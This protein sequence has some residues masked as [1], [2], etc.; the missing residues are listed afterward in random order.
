[1][2]DRLI[3]LACLELQTLNPD[4]I[5]K[6]AGVVQ[7]LKNWFKYQTNSEFKKIVDE[8]KLKSLN[9]K[10]ILKNISNEIDNF[11]EAISNGDMASYELSVQNLKNLTQ[12]LW[13]DVQETS[14][15]GKDYYTLQDLEQPGFSEWFK[16]HLPSEYDLE[17][18]KSYNSPISEFKW[19][20][21]L[22]PDQ[23]S[24]SNKS[25]AILLNQ[26]QKTLELSAEDSSKYLN[27]IEEI[28]NRF[29]ISIVQGTLLKTNIKKPSKSIEQQILGSTEIEVLTSPF[30]LPNS[31]YKLQAKV[32][33]ID[34]STSIVPRKKLSIRKIHF[35]TSLGQKLAF[36]NSPIP[37]AVTQ[38]SELDFAKVLRSSY[39]KTFGKDPSAEILAYGWAQ[40]V[41]ESGRP[42]K[43]PNNNIGNLKA[44][45]N[46]INA[47]KPYFVKST[48]EF[49]P[50][51]ER[52]IEEGASWQA[53]SSPEEGGIAYWKLLKNKFPEALAWMASGDPDSATINLAKKHYFTANIEKYAKGVS[54]L[55]QQFMKKLTPQLPNL[56]SN[57]QNPPGEKPEM[58]SWLN[59]Y[60]QNPQN[61]N[62]QIDQLLTNLYANDGKVTTF[63]KNAKYNEILPSTTVLILVEGQNIEDKINWAL[64][65]GQISQDLIQGTFNIFKKD[66]KIE[67]EIAARGLPL[68][69]G[70]AVQAIADCVSDGIDNKIYGIGGIN[71]FSNLE[72]LSY[73]KII[74]FQR[75]FLLKQAMRNL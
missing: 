30:S 46:W 16:K 34:L 43:L 63:I 49:S 72:K 54:S 28:K 11:N 32:D 51:G 69:V 73:S 61:S 48:I 5:I 25:F 1:M 57:P 35:V 2:T 6:V 58:K 27:N 59:E 68:T 24:I 64:T 20:Q 23:I 15:K 45:K 36:A 26:I 66:N 60:Q 7:R 62:Q 38:L 39:Q 55:Y 9:S 17:L 22:T 67:L 21:N 31:N 40:A 8:L 71:C 18:G 14:Q 41:L 4:Q 33:L 44:T 53:F 74:N 70:K 42:I 50:S 56:I 12:D 29:L 37:F 65:T 10:D 13:K 75:K 19:Y 52:R 47:G 3:K